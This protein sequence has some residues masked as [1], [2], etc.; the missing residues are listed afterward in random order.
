MTAYIVRRLL[1]MVLV[2][3]GVAAITFAIAFL[4]PGDPARLYAGTNASPNTVRIIHHQLGLDRP[5]D[6]QFVDYMW[7][8]RHLDFGSS[9]PY[10]TKVLPAILQRF[11]ATAEL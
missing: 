11:P 1:W 6:I 5:F 2:L 10:Q 9:Y 8:V 7:R 4:V 3:V